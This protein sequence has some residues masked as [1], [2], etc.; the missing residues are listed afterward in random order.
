MCHFYLIDLL[1]LAFYH[2]KRSSN[3]KAIT[4]PYGVVVAYR[5]LVPGTPVQTWVGLNHFL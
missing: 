2:F 4:Q 3:L 1:M 5:I